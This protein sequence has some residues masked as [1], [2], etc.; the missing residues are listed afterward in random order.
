MLKYLYITANFG[1][2]SRSIYI[3]HKVPLKLY[4]LF[5]NGN[6]SIPTFKLKSN[7]TDKQRDIRFQNRFIHSGKIKSIMQTPYDC[8]VVLWQIKC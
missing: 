4:H 8:I 6:P 3:S 7:S 5:L 1:P 2:L